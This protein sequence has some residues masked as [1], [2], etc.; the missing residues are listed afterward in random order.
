MLGLTG[1]VFAAIQLYSEA[2][3]AYRS[4]IG[5]LQ[6]PFRAVMGATRPVKALH[7][8]DPTDLLALASLLV[9]WMLY[10]RVSRALAGSEPTPT[11][12]VSEDLVAHSG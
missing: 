1:V 11:P 5:L 3:E 10:A 9:A 8:A 12:P 2:A 6:Y 4:T 7:N